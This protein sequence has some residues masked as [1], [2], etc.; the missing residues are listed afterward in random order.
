[1]TSASAN[2]G[3]AAQAN[4]YGQPIINVLDNVSGHAQTGV[5]V[6]G[7]SYTQSPQIGQFVAPGPRSNSFRN[8]ANQAKRKR[9]FWHPAFSDL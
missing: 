5:V 9:I 3:T 8:P 6:D 2:P 7:V 4:G 1:V